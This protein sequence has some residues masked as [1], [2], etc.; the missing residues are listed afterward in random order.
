MDTY[1]PTWNNVLRWHIPY[2]DI[3]S[4]LGCRCIQLAKCALPIKYP[5]IL[6]RQT[7]MVSPIAGI[8]R[9]VS[10][11]LKSLSDLADLLM[12]AL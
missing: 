3:P 2:M 5:G 7:D 12:P 9:R 10:E 8:K 1:F 4:V 11:S 6:P